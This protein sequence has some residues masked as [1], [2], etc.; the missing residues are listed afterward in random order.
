MLIPVKN[1]LPK[2]IF[3]RRYPIL[4]QDLGQGESFT[5]YPYA[6]LSQ[7]KI[8]SD[9]ITNFFYFRS[10][11]EIEIILTASPLVY[12]WISLVAI[13]MLA[14]QRSQ[15]SFGGSNLEMFKTFCME[16]HVLPIQEQE[17]FKLRL[18][19][20]SPEHLVDD[21]SQL[22][23]L[24]SLRGYCV[25]I[26]NVTQDASVP[27]VNLQIFATPKNTVLTAPFDPE[28]VYAEDQECQMQNI[29][30]YGQ[31][32][33]EVLDWSHGADAQW[34][35]S[36]GASTITDAA[37]IAASF[38]PS[39]SGIAAGARL[40]NTAFQTFNN[41]N[42]I[43][44]FVKGPVP[45]ERG[46]GERAA[47]RPNFYGDMASFAV[48][49]SYQPISDRTESDIIS[50]SYLGLPEQE[51]NMLQLSRYWAYLEHG[52]FTMSSPQTTFTYPVAPH[53]CGRSKNL[54]TDDIYDYGWFPFFSQFYR[55]WRGSIEYRLMVFGNP[56]IPMRLNW[57]ISWHKDTM[58]ATIDQ[59]WILASMGSTVSGSILVEGTTD[60][61]ISVPFLRPYLWD[62]VGDL[63]NCAYITFS[64]SSMEPQSRGASYI[65][66]P[67][68]L[69]KRAGPDLAYKSFDAGVIHPETDFAK[70]QMAQT[71]VIPQYTRF[72][73]PNIVSSSTCWASTDTL[74]GCTVLGYILEVEQTPAAVQIQ[75][76]TEYS[77]GP[78]GSNMIF[79]F[80]ASGVSTYPY[81]FQVRKMYA[82][83]LL[84]PI[85]EE[86]HWVAVFSSHN[87]T[88]FSLTII[89]TPIPSSPK[90]YI[91]EPV[92]V[93]NFKQNED[94]PLYV[95]WYKKDELVAMNQMAQVKINESDPPYL[96]EYSPAS[97]ETVCH[98]LQLGSIDVNHNPGIHQTDPSVSAWT[99]DYYNGSLTD[100]LATCCMFW[101]GSRC[102]K[103]VFASDTDYGTIAVS[104]VT[105]KNVVIDPPHVVP[106]EYSKV[107]IGTC[108]TDQNTFRMIEYER[109]FIS[110]YPVWFTCDDG[111]QTSSFGQITK[112]LDVA[113]HSKLLLDQ[114]PVPEVV[115]ENLSY[116]F[117]FI[118]RLPPPSMV[119]AYHLTGK[120]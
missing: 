21:I 99:S 65:T 18:N 59:A 28:G 119:R 20:P 87:L 111:S 44:N 50:N 95:T 74:V 102:Y 62:P 43:K 100:K 58:P 104:L 55:Y 118:L 38:V 57:V 113:L 30:I 19:W 90:S 52:D 75:M 22:G 94:L 88:G 2:Q 66:V 47:I 56:M 106:G 42:R 4:N 12:G 11:M 101:V 34:T 23:N 115:Y 49:E 60:E 13:P 54:K 81:N 112:P 120:R 27:K 33:E 41:I 48:S 35:S 98:R 15:Y 17:T 37:T 53:T 14:E 108:M 9:V 25:A 31:G 24:W 77:G 96:Q 92:W 103:A 76:E 7:R 114:T 107:E 46:R 36:S 84:M 97:F 117:K 89:H 3:S 63:T 70:D 10:D 72:H 64:I 93:S 1:E 29:P 61:T 8:L 109:P 39:F 45:Q 26:S 86:F 40:F 68:L 78:A 16:G 91:E 105:T 67:Y 73:F 116:D 51:L 85:I 5:V 6:V 71:L 110:K 83:P 79:D 80:P 32:G 69:L 82:D